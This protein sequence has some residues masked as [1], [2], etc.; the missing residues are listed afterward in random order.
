MTLYN[1]RDEPFDSVSKCVQAHLDGS[2]HERGELE[3]LNSGQYNL[4]ICVA[5]LIE[6]LVKKGVLTEK[7]VKEKV[8][9]SLFA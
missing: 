2:D 6:V 5:Q 1:Y 9:D 4:S 7:E 3:T 8:L